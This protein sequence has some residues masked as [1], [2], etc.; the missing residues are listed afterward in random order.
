METAEATSTTTPVIAFENVSKSYAIYEA[1]SDRLVELM[2]LNTVKKHRI[3][4]ALEGITFSVRA[5][6]TFC[7]IGENGSGKS[8]LLQIIAGI[9]QPS[10]GT[11]KVRGRVA[12]LLELGSGFNPEFS[13]RDNVYLNAAILG[14]S[15][16]ETDRRFQSIEEFAEIGDFLDQPVK[17]YS[18]GMTVRLAFSVAIHV[19]P[20]ILLVDEALAVGDVYFRQRCLR[21]VH[22]LRQRGVTILFVSHAM[23]DV[24]AIGDR[25]MWLDHG[26][27][28]ELGSTELVVAKY[29]AAM[30]EK[31]SDFVEHYAEHRANRESTAGMAPE[32]V[33]A[34]PNVD[35]RHGDGRA[36]IIGIAVLRETGETALMLEPN[37]KAILR[38]S[39][40]ANERIDL[41][42]IGFMMRNHMGLDFAGTNTIREG[43]ELPPMA[44]GDTI[45]VDFHLEI[46]ALYPSHFSFS[47]AIADGS[48]T[49]Y[50]MCD[51]IDNAMI[52]QMGHSEGQIYGYLH[53]PCRVEVNARLMQTS[54]VEVLRG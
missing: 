37:T 27:I 30:S 17:T 48:L 33:T 32:V 25:V 39:A 23:G 18:S 16:E 24:K 8:T 44:P 45:T 10:G 15:R 46:P 51:W 53:L 2:T 28:R 36:Q 3:F 42:N 22:E 21:K 35:H 19:D 11:A 20:E 54:E 38:I 43:H 9:L 12:A 49:H 1:P 29:L 5:G 7:I 6:E 13:G 41:P 26:R 50:K 47:P 14:L 4:N 40:R 52:L 31:D 34:V